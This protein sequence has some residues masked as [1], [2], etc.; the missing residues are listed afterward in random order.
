MILLYVSILFAG[1]AQTS[2]QAAGSITKE[3]ISLQEKVVQILRNNAPKG[4]EA[5]TISVADQT[6][7]I[8]NHFKVGDKCEQHIFTALLHDVA[9]DQE[10]VKTLNL[11]GEDAIEV[12]CHESRGACFQVDPPLRHEEDGKT[13]DIKT[14]RNA[15]LHIGISRDKPNSIGEL[16]EN[17]RKLIREEKALSR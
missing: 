4:C 1:V 10:P 13:S 15:F 16:K 6:I 5:D 14:V 7:V 8:V 9:S 17:L 12:R 11:S 3:T 2:T